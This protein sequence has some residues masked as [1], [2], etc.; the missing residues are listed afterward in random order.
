MPAPDLT[1]IAGRIEAGVEARGLS[2]AEIARR[3][4]MT[5][6]QA[7][8]RIKTGE[9]RGSKHLD[10]LCRELRCTVTWLQ[11][12]NGVQP[13]WL[14]P[15]PAQ[16]ARRAEAP[17]E[18]YQSGSESVETA[19]RNAVR[20]LEDEVKYLRQQNMELIARLGKRHDG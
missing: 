6:R 15:I 11:T 13:V 10:G 2:A 14:E 20:L 16:D 1:T 17:A 7:I 3:A 19:L 9:L 18:R 8:T 5:N 4:G 12:G